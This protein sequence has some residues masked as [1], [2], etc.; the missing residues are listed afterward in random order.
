M[1][2]WCPAGCG[3]GY[4]CSF[5]PFP[6]SEIPLRSPHNCLCTRVFA[7]AAVICCA[8]RA[9]PG[10]G[11]KSL[12]LFDKVFVFRA[13]KGLFTRMAVCG[14]GYFMHRLQTVNGKSLQQANGDGGG[15]LA[16]RERETTLANCAHSAIGNLARNQK[17]L[18][19]WLAGRHIY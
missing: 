11:R 19:G 15:M 13:P 9:V 18:A 17:W 1:A 6:K 12:L 16:A 3:Y 2:I 7:S 10:S 4:G 8:G 14:A 5:F